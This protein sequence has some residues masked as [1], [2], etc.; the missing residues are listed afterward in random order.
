MQTGRNRLRG[1]IWGMFS[2]FVRN[3][4]G[5]CDGID[6][7]KKWRLR[8]AVDA[9]LEFLSAL[10]KRQFLRLDFHLFAGLG[11]AAGIALVALDEK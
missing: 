7:G 11:I 5:Q 9:V 4:Q 3:N 2:A 8:L 1:R 6:E 10:E